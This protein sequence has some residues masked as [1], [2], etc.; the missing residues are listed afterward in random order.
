MAS[1]DLSGARYEQGETMGVVESVKA[2]SDVY[3]PVSGE[4]VEVVCILH[5]PLRKCDNRL[6]SCS[7]TAVTVT[8]Q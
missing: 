5:L 4:I 7:F 3:A 8:D 1:C 2:A 6:P